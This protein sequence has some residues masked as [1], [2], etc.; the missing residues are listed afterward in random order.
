[1]NVESFPT[2][3]KIKYSNRKLSGNQPNS[4][5]ILPKIKEQQRQD[6]ERL[7]VELFELYLMGFGTGI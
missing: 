5:L 7:D 3:L 6:K 2:L 4:C 1:M